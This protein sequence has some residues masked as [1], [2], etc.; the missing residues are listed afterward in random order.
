MKLFIEAFAK[1]FSNTTST[2]GTVLSLLGMV[3]TVMS[4]QARSK[5][6]LLIIQTIGSTLFFISYFF[7]GGIFG[8]IINSYYLIRNFVFMA[9]D[10]GK[11]RRKAKIACALFCTLYVLTYAVYTLINK[12]DLI[13]GLLNTLPVLASIPGTIALIETRPVRLRLWKY[14]DSICWLTYN[15][16]VLSL[17]GILC[18]IF[19]LTSNTIS[20]IRF[21]DRKKAPDE[22]NDLPE[23][24]S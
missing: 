16:C 13:T 12:P 1:M 18:E 6:W 23:G 15:V 4:F 17:G 7:L 5:K 21:R 20:I 3:F 11:D 14:P 10:S 19:N 8:A 22:N 2:I 24:T 9:I